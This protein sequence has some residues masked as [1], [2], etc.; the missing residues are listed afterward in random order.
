MVGSGGYAYYGCAYYGYTYY[1]YMVGG[2][3]ELLEVAQ[4]HEDGQAEGVV[5][6]RR[7]LKRGE[8]DRDRLL[9]LLAW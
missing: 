9:R 3:R 6:A 7:A 5:H 4:S 1:G 8:G 2:A